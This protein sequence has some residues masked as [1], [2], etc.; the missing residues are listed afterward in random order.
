MN[1]DELRLDLWC[2]DEHWMSYAHSHELN[3]DLCSRQCKLA[4]SEI[5]MAAKWACY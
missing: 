1:T 4:P 5:T 2:Q 3:G